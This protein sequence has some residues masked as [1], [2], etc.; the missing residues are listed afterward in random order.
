MYVSCVLIISILPQPKTGWAATMRAAIGFILLVS[1]MD[2]V[3]QLQL[4]VRCRSKATSEACEETGCSSTCETRIGDNV[5]LGMD[6][7]TA[8]TVV[9]RQFPRACGPCVIHDLCETKM[10]LH[11]CPTAMNCGT[12]GSKILH[13]LS[14]GNSDALAKVAGNE[15]VCSACGTPRGV[16]NVCYAVWNTQVC[17]GDS[18]KTCGDRITEE[19]TNGRKIA[20]SMNIIGSQFSLCSDCSSLPRGVPSSCAPYWTM[21]A[22]GLECGMRINRKITNSVTGD[23]AATMVAE[24]FPMEC[25]GCA[26]PTGV[27]AKCLSVWSTK[28]D[29]TCTSGC[30]TCGSAITAAVNSGSTT[31]ASMISVAATNSVCGQCAPPTGVS[32][33]CYSVFNNIVCEYGICNKCSDLLDNFVSDNL[34][35]AEAMVR[36]AT[37]APAECGYCGVSSGCLA[38][39]NNPSCGSGCTGSVQTCGQVV[40][41]SLSQRLHSN[42]PEAL[43]AAARQY[44][45]CSACAFPVTPAPVAGTP[46]PSSF[47]DT[48]QLLWEDKF[49]ATGLNP[50][51]WA[52]DNGNGED[53]E[54]Q[55]YA[56]S[57]V[58]VSGRNLLI[59]ATGGITTTNTSGR[60]TTRGL[61]EITY[62]YVEVRMKPPAAAVGASPRVWFAS[63]DTNSM[64]VIDIFRNS[65][66]RPQTVHNFVQTQANNGKNAIEFCT[67]STGSLFNPRCFNDVSPAKLQDEFHTYAMEWSPFA[68]EFYIDDVHVGVYDRPTAPTP[69]NWPFTGKFYLNIALALGGEFADNF[70]NP[71]ALPYTMNVDYVKVYQKT[72]LVGVE[73]PCLLVANKFAC[74][75]NT[76]K[77]CLEWV[78]LEIEN[79][80]L[81]PEEAMAVVAKKFTAVCGLCGVSN[82]CHTETFEKIACSGTTCSTQKCGELITTKLNSNDSNSFSAA[83]IIGKQY[84]TSCGE[85]TVPSGVTAACYVLWN[86]RACDANNRCSTCGERVRMMSARTTL[87]IQSIMN[88]IGFEFSQ[89][90]ACSSVTA[91]VPRLCPLAWAVDTCRLSSTSTCSSLRCSAVIGNLVSNGASITDAAMQAAATHP[92]S[93]QQCSSIEGITS[94]CLAVWN[95]NAC[96]LFDICQTCGFRI[97]ALVTSG[98]SPAAAMTVTGS[99]FTVCS[100]CNSPTGITEQCYSTFT[101]MACDVGIL[102]SDNVCMTCGVRI[103]KLL[104]TKTA[105]EAMLQV[106]MQYPKD[107]GLCGIPN[108]CYEIWNT[109]TAVQQPLQPPP[110]TC[111]KVISDKLSES[112]QADVAMSDISILYSACSE[113]TPATPPTPVSTTILKTH[114]LVWEDT[115]STQTLNPSSWTISTGSGINNELQTYSESSVSIVNNKLVLTASK[116]GNTIESGRV[117]TKGNIDFTF[118]YLEISAK[119]PPAVKGS[120]TSLKL[121]SSVGSFPNDGEISI[122]DILG[123]ISGVITS[124][125]E[126]QALNG[127]SATKKCLLTKTSDP[128]PNCNEEIK[129]PKTD[130]Y[131]GFHKYAIQWTPAGITTYFDEHQVMRI[132]KPPGAPRN[133]WPFGKDFSIAL[134]LAVGGTVGGASGVDETKFPYTLEVDSIKLYRQP[135][136]QG[137]V[138]P[139]I[140]AFYNSR[141]R[142]NVCTTCGELIERE[143]KE[144]KRSAIDAMWIVGTRNPTVCGKCTI[145]PK[146]Y[147]I[148]ATEACSSGVCKTCESRINVELQSSNGNAA[149]KVGVAF[150]T[151]CGSCTIQ[152]QC[153]AI[154]FHKVCTDEDGC[155]SCGDRINTLV[156]TTSSTLT[157]A[158][159]TIGYR[160]PDVCG[161]CSVVTRGVPT[162]CAPFWEFN[163]CDSSGICKTCGQRINEAAM[164]STTKSDIS[165]GVATDFPVCRGCSTIPGVPS[166]CLGVWDTI[167]CAGSICE[168][169]GTRIQNI[170]TANSYSTA[171]AMI[172]IASL[173]PTSCGPCGPPAGVTEWC[174]EHW[175]AATCN[176][177]TKVCNTCGSLI[178]NEITVGKAAAEAMLSVANSQPKSCTLCGVSANC[179]RIW[180]SPSC[181]TNC[182]A[183]SSTCG[184]LIINLIQDGVFTLVREAATAVARQYPSCS[185][186]GDTTPVP[187]PTSGIPTT[188]GSDYH[189]VW[190][191]DFNQ[192]AIDTSV[193][194]YSLGAG[195]TNEVQSFTQ[196]AV[197]VRDGVLVITAEQTQGGITSGRIHTKGTKDFKYGYL[198]ISAKLPATA[199]GARVS[200]SML[201]TEEKYGAWPD[202]GSINV[203]RQ[204]GDEAGTIYSALNSQAENRNNERLSC[205]LTLTSVFNP[206]CHS[207]VLNDVTTFRVY[208]MLWT[209]TLV[210]IY[211]DGVTI[212]SFPRVTQTTASWPFI[213]NFYP[214]ISLV[215]L[216][217]DADT[218][219][220]PYSL[221]VNYIKFY[222][223]PAATTP[224]TPSTRAPIPPGDTAVPVPIG[225][226][227]VEVALVISSISKPQASSALQSMVTKLMSS[228]ALNQAR[229]IRICSVE[230]AS[231]NSAWNEVGCFK[232]DGTSFSRGVTQLVTTGYRGYIQGATGL[233]KNDLDTAVVTAGREVSTTTG[234]TYE[235]AQTFVGTPVPPTPPPPAAPTLAPPPTPIPVQVH[236][237]KFNATLVLSGISQSGFVAAAAGFVTEVQ[238]QL[239]GT[240]TV[241]CRKLCASTLANGNWSDGVCYKCDGSKLGRSFVQLQNGAFTGHAEGVTDKD[242]NF[243]QRTVQNA[244]LKT[245]SNA[246][247]VLETTTSDLQ[248]DVIVT[249][250]P[251]VLIRADSTEDQSIII[252]SLVICAGLILISIIG[253]VIYTKCCN[254]KSEKTE[255][256]EGEEMEDGGDDVLSVDGKEN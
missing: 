32:E 69:R 176:P 65:G 85:C 210:E 71:A 204:N 197:S 214:D 140:S 118:G 244:A 198:E 231:I 219:V 196:E 59:T 248:V 247:A 58:T 172:S 42:V 21:N 97:A 162:T 149:K 236:Q 121:E 104:A 3:A 232:C 66:K 145:N 91:G 181:I 109:L 256:V 60:I 132:P 147:E 43:T 38:I 127:N 113:C 170:V 154:W 34:L 220:M 77:T 179:Y 152:P 195:G 110:A 185:A 246:G 251:A 105:A 54:I 2:A 235:D 141:C 208:S 61:S 126:T 24:Q 209:E 165:M 4:T 56:Q 250:E 120:V 226:S 164:P 108:S 83:Q 67:L 190:V 94:T 15:A 117:T 213:E 252:A 53:G 45:P 76:C 20:T 254:K 123:S 79:D 119:M 98:S 50:Q 174:Y 12:C 178:T 90:A 146:C 33:L 129:K 22:N 237:K 175:N 41:N 55:T 171:E 160:Y 128:D 182:P 8:M 207:T 169:C 238:T 114:K 168:T 239:A 17:V 10:D 249:A 57:A 81:K 191:E 1:C 200:L 229:C 30:A 135:P 80:G 103:M 234:G 206:K 253:A 173:F 89:C 155:I 215:V 180:R 212:A 14:N 16:T 11:A 47:L 73:G 75:V 88:V 221:E 63:T 187:S 7:D 242:S 74:E 199:K 194:Q 95:T 46:K 51:R 39:W 26:T 25:L 35:I 153:H 189:L 52:Y 166:N 96:G 13:E 211:I 227:G 36:V 93:C 92:T 224:P 70:A 137:V 40:Q 150:P 124:K 130:L 218:T 86:T 233:A 37:N 116:N 72:A 131:T 78:T 23:V 62:G 186:C 205:G 31:A 202:S 115:F 102:A 48:F 201:P 19:Y 106:S 82:L 87:S 240:S 136:P 216:G 228:Q 225:Q 84:P 223:I 243:L 192:P 6:V 49:E 158:M 188:V 111:G 9:G 100:P 101:R 144:E 138:E 133:V 29:S 222:Q 184:E 245:A 5:A 107:C 122:G 44:S 255:E 68:I 125:I 112:I 139:C 142:G 167:A 163:A 143:I 241:I 151:E 193:W 159:N 203:V 134:S 148:R 230:R 156:Q 157:A 99:D 161:S 177:T 183:V 217:T 28:L 18:C 64:G 27:T